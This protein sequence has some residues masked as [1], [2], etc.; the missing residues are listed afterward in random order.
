MK[1]DTTCKSAIEKMLEERYGEAKLK[2]WREVYSPRSV[3]V[4]TVED[5]HAVLRPLTATELARY[6]VLTADSTAGLDIAS[7]YLLEELWLD[8]DAE[9]KDNE[10]YFMAAMLQLQYAIELKKSGYMKL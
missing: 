1:K 6:S 4:I 10:E 3:S 8:G 7:R 5:K 2:E 9:L